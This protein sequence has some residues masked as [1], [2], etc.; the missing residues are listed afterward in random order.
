[1]RP[2]SI[3]VL[4]VA[5]L[6][7]AAVGWLLLSFSYST[8]PDLPWSP[9]IV[10]AVLAVAE[11]LLAQNTAARIQRKPGTPRVDPLA[12]AR[13]VALAK[14]SSLVGA[15]SAGFSIGLLAWLAMEPTQAANND[16]P[17]AVGSAVSAAALIGAA[18]WLER[19]CRVPEQPEDENEKDSGRPTGLL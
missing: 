16:L 11:G 9:V 7:A 2:T 1:M 17:V 4:I 15:I 13:Y 8:L 3:S 12:V 14:A 18:L 10:L 5:G 6:A 19:A